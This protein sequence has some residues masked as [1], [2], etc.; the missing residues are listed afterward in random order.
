MRRTMRA[1]AAGALGLSAILATAGPAAAGVVP[2]TDPAQAG[3]IGLCDTSGHNITSGSLDA[4]PFVARAVASVAAPPPFNGNRRSATLFAYQPRQGVTPAEWS[5][6]EISGGTLY[7]N[8]AHPTAVGTK[9]DITMGQFV[10]DFPPNWE[11]LVQLRM[12][13]AAAAPGSDSLAYAAADLKIDGNSWRVLKGADVSCNSGKAV[14][15]VSVLAPAAAAGSF[16]PALSAPVSHPKNFPSGT[17]SSSGAAS[18]SSAGSK[19]NGGSSLP[20]GYVGVGGLAALL[21]IALLATKRRHIREWS[22]Q[23]GLNKR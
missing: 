15:I 9:G 21:A 10:S 18:G 1:L 22:A 7:E 23:R 6:E 11:G 19:S 20:V 17:R 2:Y 3:Y 16:N 13:F 5:G 4:V 8:P 12:Y 14:S